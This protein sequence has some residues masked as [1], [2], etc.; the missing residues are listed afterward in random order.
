MSF[1]MPTNKVGNDRMHR[2]PRQ[3]QLEGDYRGHGVDD[4][5]C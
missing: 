5:D 4:S 2:A 3:P 1:G